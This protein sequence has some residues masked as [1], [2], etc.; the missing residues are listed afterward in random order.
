MKEGI[1]FGWRS[2]LCPEGLY[3][4]AALSPLSMWF[5]FIAKGQLSDCGQSSCK[6]PLKKKKVSLA[7][8]REER[9]RGPGMGS[10]CPAVACFED[11]DGLVPGREKVWQLEW[12]EVDSEDSGVGKAVPPRNWILL[13]G[14]AWLWILPQSFQIKACLWVPVSRILL[15]L[16]KL[17]QAE[18][19]GTKQCCSE[20]LAGGNLLFNNRQLL[21]QAG[22]GDL[23]LP[24]T[25]LPPLPPPTFTF[26]CLKVSFDV[27]EINT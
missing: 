18:L 8:R 11:R 23:W 24:Y 13:V 25:A 12:P 17:W 26:V 5:G 9:Q 16:P 3:P 4:H 20:L 21:H 7:G 1:I 2:E 6:S 19:R 14:W 22:H 15:N 27:N 10:T